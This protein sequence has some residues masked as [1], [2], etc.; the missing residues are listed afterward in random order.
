MKFNIRL[1]FIAFTFCIVLLVGGSISLYSVLKGRERILATFAQDAREITTVI[2]GTV[3]NDL[4]FLDLRSLRRRLQSA[5]VNPD[6]RYIYVTG[7]E[8]L[9]LSD[10]TG[11]NPLRDQRL[12]DSFSREV[13]LSKDWISRVEGDL[14]KVGGPVFLP[15]GARVGHLHVGFS[16][17]HA[18]E[19]AYGTTKESLYITLVCLGIGA[20]LAVFLSTTFTRPILS[21]VEAS[22]EIGEGKLDVRLSVKR[23][24]ELGVLASSINQMAKGLS[25]NLQ[26][27][28]ALREIDTAITST[29]DLREVLSVL[30]EKIDLALPYAAATVRLFNDESRI[31]EAVA[32]RNL[33]EEEWKEAE[34]KA[35]RGPAN[36]VFEGRAPLM[37]SNV[38][39]D[40]R[41]KD[42]S[43]FRR[44][45]L[46]SYLGVPLIVREKI[47]GVLG[48]YTKEEHQ[49][50]DEEVEFLTTLGG[51]AAIAIHNSQLYEETKRQTV[52]LERANRVKDE[53]LSV[54]SHELRTPLNVVMGY[55][56]MIKDR[57]LGEINPEQERALGKVVSRSKELLTMISGI[58][59]VTRIEAEEVRVE[60]DRV[61]LGDFLR[62]LESTYALP[63]DKEVRVHWDYPRDLPVVETDK[64]KLKL[65][66]QNLISNA[67]KF[68]EK[69]TVTI[70]ARVREDG[71]TSASSVEPQQAPDSL[72]PGS[73]LLPRPSSRFVEFRVADTGIGIAKEF[74]PIIFEKFHQVDSSETRPYGG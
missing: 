71:R 66:L 35:G 41:V 56:G 12:S 16:L 48:F 55:T 3:V 62:E 63:L 25:S 37:I 67:I 69:G 7:L 53:F 1:K 4:Y 22:R 39:T 51:Q 30:L 65:V 23:G 61:K 6:V 31:L 40:P 36:A 28:R 73:R 2:S 34:G 64:E 50:N 70:S 10:G 47:L 49:F 19:I 44:H 45:G 43:F 27:I 32:C 14:L 17:R 18:Y 68:T 26:R 8:G 33:D 9:V 57:M 59:E 13:L 46:V 20:L 21:I 38:Q 72:I 52:E 24:D 29:L 58:L 74:F 5:R 15:D 42:P 60:R 54:M 11:E